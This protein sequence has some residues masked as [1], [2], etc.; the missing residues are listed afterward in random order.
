MCDEK[1]ILND[2]LFLEKKRKIKLHCVSFLYI[3]ENIY[4]ES[5]LMFIIFLKIPNA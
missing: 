3:Y 2:K 1:S 4:A 5:Y